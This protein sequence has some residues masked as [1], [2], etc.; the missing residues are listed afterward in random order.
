MSWSIPKMWE[1]QTACILASG[2]SM[3]QEV[4]DAVRPTLWRTI[5]INNQYQKAPWADMLYACDALW[6]NHPD[7][8]SARQFTGLKVSME[9]VGED[10]LTL[11]NT[12]Q[13]GMD[14]DPSCLRTGNNSGYQALQVAVHAG[15]PRIILCGFD[16]R[17]VNGKQHCHERHPLPLRDHGDGIYPRWIR[18]FESIALILVKK[19]VEV[20]NATPDSA[21]KCFPSIKLGDAITRFVSNTP[22]VSL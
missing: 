9:P 3:N 14:E 7:Y 16:M 12:G 19:K 1:G 2:P 18:A 11:K 13:H 15:C 10:V 21:L 4:A 20:W 5:A 8:R 17:S 6:W 22:A